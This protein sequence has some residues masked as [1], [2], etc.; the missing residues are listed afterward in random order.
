MKKIITSINLIIAILLLA[1]FSY[2]QD[3]FDKT[4]IDKAK[5]IILQTKQE[6]ITLK[7][8][9]QKIINGDLNETQKEQIKEQLTFYIE[10]SFNIINDPSNEEQLQYFQ[11]NINKFVPKEYVSIIN[12]YINIAKLDLTTEEKIDLFFSIYGQGCA[13]IFVA[14]ELIALVGLGLAM[15]GI[16]LASLFFWSIIMFPIATA[17]M[18]AGLFILVIGLPLMALAIF[19]A[20]L[21]Y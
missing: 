1:N 7:N 19:C 21:F 3:T 18:G 14:G 4:V 15:V 9:R 2:G 20:L 6:I 12:D 16:V 11:S 10:R 5:K 8:I 13:I 17:L